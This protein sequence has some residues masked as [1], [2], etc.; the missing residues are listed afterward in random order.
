MKKNPVA[1]GPASATPESSLSPHYQL[2]LAATRLA[3]VLATVF[4]ARYFYWRASST[5][6]PVARV[7]FY[8][9][10]VAEAL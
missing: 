10:L 8:A 7:F 6:N 2:K 1:E 3:M 5:L 4:T 9:F